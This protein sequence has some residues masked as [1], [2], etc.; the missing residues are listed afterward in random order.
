MWI[1]RV[2]KQGNTLAMTF[3][4]QMQRALKMHPRDY[5]AMILTEQDTVEIKSIDSMI[6]TIEYKG[7]EKCA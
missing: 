6:G 7:K 5:Y 1:T 2:Y 4:K 3:P